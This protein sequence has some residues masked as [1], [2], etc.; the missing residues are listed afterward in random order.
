M[1]LFSAYI[2]LIYLCVFSL[3]AV[4]QDD[5]EKTLSLSID[6]VTV[7]GYRYRSA[8][9]SEAGG[10]M[11]WDLQKM[12]ELPQILGNADP[13]HYAQTLPGIQTNSEMRSGINIQGCENSHNFVSISGA[14][15]YNVHHLLGFFS[16]FNAS[17]YSS[18]LLDKTASYAGASNRLG[19]ELTMELPVQ[20]TDTLSAELSVGLISSQGTL[21]L[22][23]GKRTSLAVSLRGSYMNLLYSRWLQ[24]EGNQ[25]RY[26]FYDANATLVHRIDKKNTLMLDYYGGNDRL[27]VEEDS[28][29]AKMADRWGNQMGALHWLHGIGSEGLQANTTLYVTSFHNQFTLSMQDMHFRLPSSITDL[30]LKSSLGLGRWNWGAELIWHHIHPQSLESKGSYNQSDGSQPVTRSAEGSLFAQYDQPLARHLSLSLG[31]RGSLYLQSGKDYGAADPSVRIVYD[32]R[33][34]QFSAGYALKH[35]Y[36]FQTGFST[37]GL[38]SEFWLSCS[39]ERPPQYAHEL[40]ARASVYLLNRRYRLEADAYYK[41][42]Y[43]QVEYKGSV[44]DYMNLRY[45]IERNL[46]YGSG[47][48][49]GFSLMLTKCS[50]RLTG[51]I[52][53]A[54]SHARRTF[55]EQRTL[56]GTYPANH[57]RPHELNVVLS[58]PLNRYWSFGG[59]YVYASGTPFTALKHLA[60]VNGNLLLKYGDY[61]GSRMKPYSRLNLSV[62]YKWHTSFARE[63]GVNFTLYNALGQSS[64][65]FYYISVQGGGEFAYRPVNFFVKILPSLSYFCK[66]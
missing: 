13:M 10:M 49:Y 45:D 11:R 8:V 46:L 54:Y 16:A 25:M 20:K 55:A 6:S 7:R 65:L 38:P 27:S 47:N 44:L 22:P 58:Y 57:D 63:Q 14:P 35:Q 2:L 23:L 31:L 30:G 9:K 43:H 29:F 32:D 18:M 24:D 12:G 28:Y 56:Q 40:S 19:G 15:L 66:F 61:N 39:K 1:R 4:A 17:H 34:L 21:R 59:T 62:N 5:K 26:S 3:S 64:Q 33:T 48:N 52:S 42:L 36:L 37:V 41:R 50:G 60:Y 53:Y 51:W